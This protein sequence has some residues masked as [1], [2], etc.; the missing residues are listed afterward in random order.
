MKFSC[1]FKLKFVS[2]GNE[3]GFGIDV[4]GAVCYR[5]GEFS[6]NRP[7]ITEEVHQRLE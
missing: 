5:F 3:W 2:F 6:L 7:Q 1:E 4:F